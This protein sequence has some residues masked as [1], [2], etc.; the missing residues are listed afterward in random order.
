MTWLI[1]VGIP[2]P[3]CGRRGLPLCPAYL[4]AMGRAALSFL[5]LAL[6]AEPLDDGGQ[7]A[8]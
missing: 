1:N 8:R 7:I 2:D 4:E 6:C 5:R 3:V